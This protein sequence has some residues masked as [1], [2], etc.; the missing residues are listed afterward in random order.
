[1]NGKI[2]LSRGLFALIDPED[3]DFINCWKWYA[4]ARGLGKF[5]AARSRWLGKGRS[6]RCETVYM[7]RLLLVPIGD[8]EIDHINHNGLDNRRSNLRLVTRA[9]NMR[10]PSRPYARRAPEVR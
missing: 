3:Y 1:M 8:L 2:V 9:E 10:N 4:A 6:H 5:Y 7:H